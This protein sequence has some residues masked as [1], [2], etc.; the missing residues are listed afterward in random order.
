MLAYIVS[1]LVYLLS[2][3]AV[4]SLTNNL[5]LALMFKLLATSASL[6]Y[7]RK[8]LPFR[9]RFD[10]LAV[11]AGAL[12]F[13]VWVGLDPFYFQSSDPVAPFSAVLD[14]L[15]KLTISVAL[16][17]VIEEFFTRYFLARILINKNWEK[18]PLG[19]YD[20]LSFI[21]TVLFFGF[22]HDRWLAG[23]VTG[24]LLN[25]LFYKT[26][27]IESCILAHATANVLLGIFVIYTGS[28]QFW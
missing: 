27:N 22:S 2:Y 17:P 16:A 14:I 11:L 8:S 9:I 12:I 24:I 26:K 13:F 20:L 21:V 3:P 23:I 25:L 6:F 15:L 7:F 5:L 10:I 28:W 1:L 4:F 19:K 18:V